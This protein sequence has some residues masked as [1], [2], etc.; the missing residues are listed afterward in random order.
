[1]KNIPDQQTG[2][3]SGI[4]EPYWNLRKLETVR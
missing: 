3:L 2:V 4:G 1:M